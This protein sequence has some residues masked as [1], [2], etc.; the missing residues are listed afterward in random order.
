MLS[1]EPIASIADM[2]RQ[3]KVGP[4]D[5]QHDPVASYGQ[6]STPRVIIVSQQGHNMQ[7]LDEVASWPSRRTGS[8]L[9]SD[10]ETSQGLAIVDS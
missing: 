5:E 7:R 3:A 10:L 4:L 8:A 1:L 2:I 9:F 6:S